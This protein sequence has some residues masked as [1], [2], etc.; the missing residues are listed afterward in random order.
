MQVVRAAL[1]TLLSIL[2]VACSPRE[3]LMEQLVGMQARYFDAYDTESEFA[4]LTDRVYAFRWHN[5]RTIVIRTDA[6]LVITDPYNPL[7][8]AALKRHLERDLPGQSVHSLIYSHYHL[9]HVRGGKVLAPN[10]VVAHQRCPQYWRDLDMS[11]V[12]APTQLISGDQTRNVGGVEIHL[13]DLGLSHTDTMYAVYLPG[14]KLLFTA[15]MGL[16][17]TL[18]PLG[19]G[20]VYLPGAMAA[21][22]RL[23]S[24]DFET[25]VPSHFG[26]GTKADLIDYVGFLRSLQRLT[27]DA[28]ATYGDEAGFPSDSEGLQQVFRHIY[29]PLKQRYGG[30]HGFNEM[31]LFTIAVGIHREAVGY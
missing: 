7:A 11:D 29:R 17:R 3:F 24:L 15:D 19:M 26:Y 5:D 28:R 30:W 12:A 21:F 1:I 14:E 25:F 2:L 13:L 23:T 16:V 27:R 8:A 20:N 4:Q 9:D 31:A 22:D 18:P 6:G 10:E